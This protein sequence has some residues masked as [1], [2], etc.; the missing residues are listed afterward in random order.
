MG[1]RVHSSQ[2]K[3]TFS[4]KKSGNGAYWLM[5][6]N[7]HLVKIQNRINS[8]PEIINYFSV[9]PVACCLF[10]LAFFPERSNA[11]DDMEGLPFL[12]TYDNLCINF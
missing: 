4:A 8:D 2:W 5:I 6:L 10:P 1:W 12:E 3:K 7:R 9:L 11:V